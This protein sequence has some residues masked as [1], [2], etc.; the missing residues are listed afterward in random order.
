MRQSKSSKQLSFVLA[1]CGGERCRV[2]SGRT[3]SGE[4][5]PRRK[6]PNGAAYRRRRADDMRRW[7]SRQ[8]RGTALFMLE[9]G[10][11]EYDL[12]IK[13]VGLKENQVGNKTAVS[14]ALGR[15]LHRALV[16]L[17][18]EEKRRGIKTR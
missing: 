5:V 13:F 8:R 18:R 6:R 1:S 15:L 2:G 14:A 4:N 7:R 3:G 10:P 12:A 16:A 11:H 9:A 17:L